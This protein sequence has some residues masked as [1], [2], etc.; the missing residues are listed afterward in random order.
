[1]QHV[2][3]LAPAIVV[4]QVVPLGNDVVDRAAVVAKRNAAIHAAC[5]LVAR[6]LV[7]QRDD[8]FVVVFEAIG[9]RDVVAVASADL[10]E[11]CSLTHG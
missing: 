1:V 10:D 4:D 11:S 3:R 8:E 5:R 2:E 7:F 9:N 6:G